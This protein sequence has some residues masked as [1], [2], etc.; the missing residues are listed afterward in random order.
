MPH[1][2]CVAIGCQNAGSR[3][4]D[5]L[6]KF[7]EMVLPN[8]YRRTS[9]DLEVTPAMI[10]D[11]QEAGYIVVRGLLD[12]WEVE[13]L[14]DLFENNPDIRENIF[15]LMGGEVYL[16]HSKVMMKEA[17]AGGSYVW[18]QD[19][20]Y[21]Y[22]NGNLFPDMM[23]VFTALDPWCSEYDEDVGADADEGDAIFFHSLVLHGSSKNTSPLRRWAYVNSFNMAR[24]SSV[25]DHHH[26]K[27]NKLHKVPN[28]A[29]KECANFSDMSGK[30]FINNKTTDWYNKKGEREE[31]E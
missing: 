21:W 18:H 7:P 19:Y 3:K 17:F 9:E 5:K 24:N 1:Y 28:S 20:G 4:S 22:Q 2:H 26:P 13:K 14:K 11:F 30:G 29:L 31:D 8:E 15:T 16:Y 23:T 27:Y 12:Q 25:E 10:K 6:E